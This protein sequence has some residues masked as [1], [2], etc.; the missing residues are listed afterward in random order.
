[1][2]GFYSYDVGDIRILGRSL[3][4]L[5]LENARRLIAYVP[6]EPY[7][8]ETSIMENIRYGKL[9]ASDEEVIEAAKQANANEFILKQKNG[10]DT[11][12]SNRG[13]SLSGGERQRVA[14]ARAILKD[15]PIILFDEATSALDNESERLIQEAIAKLEENKTVTMIAHRKATIELADVEIMI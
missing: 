9:D 7:L 3:E 15:A 1:M 8:F 6:Q 11:V 5:G 13:Q 14:I 12:I 4:T 10:Y 2:L